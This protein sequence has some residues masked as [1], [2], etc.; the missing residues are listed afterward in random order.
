MRL[1][2]I[3]ISSLGIACAAVALAA[4][5]GGGSDAAPTPLTAAEVTPK[6][7][8]AGIDCTETANR[9][10]E[11]GIAATAV[12]CALGDTGGVVVIVATSADEVAKAKLE[13]CAQAAE[14]Q[15]GLELAFG[16]TW[17]SVVLSTQGVQ[18]QQVADA[19]GGQ[20]Q[21]VSE[22]CA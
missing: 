11:E 19:L 3:G 6:L 2:T 17:L 20:V 7:E 5:G 14:E 15:G 18:A 1:S 9:P 21:K 8:A 13:L 16:D 22:Y 10:L 12:T 4:C